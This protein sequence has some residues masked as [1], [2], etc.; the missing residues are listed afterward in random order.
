MQ[1]LTSREARTFTQEMNILFLGKSKATP[2][3]I[4]QDTAISKKRIE[5]QQRKELQQMTREVWECR[6]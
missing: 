1:T 4:A 5:W 6:A 2:N 3:Q